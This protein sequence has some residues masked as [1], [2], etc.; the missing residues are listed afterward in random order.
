MSEII[1]K[2]PAVRR[3]ASGSGAVL[4][5]VG[6]LAAAFGLASCCA[7]PLLLTTIG[8]STAWLGGVGLLAAP[9]RGVLL[10]IG[11]L[12]LVGGAALLWGR[13]RAERR[14]HAARR[15]G[16]NLGGAFDGSRSTLGRIR[17]CLTQL[18]LWNQRSRVRTAVIVRPRPCR[19]MPANTSTTAR[20]AVRF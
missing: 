6:G 5:T 18:S 7:L 1:D 2:A 10:V 8:V 11:A 9:H 13:L 4:F 14:L 3:P 15:S 17:L 12:C 16:A 20:G 19:W